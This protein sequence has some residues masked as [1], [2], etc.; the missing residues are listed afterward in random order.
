[1]SPKQRDSLRTVL[2][3]IGAALVSFGVLEESLVSDITGAVVLLAPFIWQVM[4][5]D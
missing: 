3:A 1:M 4:D 2:G 5:R